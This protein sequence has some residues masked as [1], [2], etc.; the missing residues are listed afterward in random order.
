[1]TESDRTVEPG[2]LSALVDRDDADELWKNLSLDWNTGKVASG[3]R[4][5]TMLIEAGLA[6]MSSS[7]VGLNRKG[8]LFASRLLLPI[9]SLLKDRGSDLRA[10]NYLLKKLLSTGKNS[11]IYMAEHAILRSRVVVKILRPGA[12][13]DI[14]SSLRHLGMADI[15][16]AVVKP[17]DFAELEVADIFGNSAPVYCLVFPMV[18]GIHFSD[19]IAQKSS[20]LNSFVVISFIRQVG[21]AL[22]SLEQANAYHG[23]LHERNILVDWSPTGVLTFRIVDV[24]Y[25]SMGSATLEVCRN[26][27]LVRFRQHILKLLAEQ[28]HYLPR[29]SMRKY[30]GT[31][32]YTAIA[33]ILSPD[34]KS[35]KRVLSI[36]E[37]MGPA[38]DYATER[39]RF[40]DERFGTP[41]SFR[42]Q[43]FEE[44]V[45]PA[46]AIKLFVP[47]QELKERIEVFGNVY[48]SGNRGSGK[49][50]YLAS[51]AYFPTVTDS[52]RSFMTSFGIYFPCRQG[53]FA[54]LSAS[55]EMSE[56]EL[57]TRT[58]H[59]LIVKV[60]RR[61]IESLAGGLNKGNVRVVSDLYP[62]VDFLNRFVAGQGIVSVDGDII[63]ELESLV[64]SITRL[65]L[66]LVSTFRRDQSS[67]S[68]YA[69]PR[70][71]I[72][73]FSIVKQ[74]FSE[75]SATQFHILFDDAGAPYMPANVQRAVCDLMLASN[76]VFC[77]KLTAEKFTFVF[78]SS[79]DKV[80]ENGNDYVEQD[81]SAILF[82]GSHTAGLSRHRL[83]EYFR[84]IVEQRLVHF[85]YQT[86]DIVDYLGDG[87]DGA[88]KLIGLLA[89]GRKDAYYCGWT[90]VWNV[91]DRTPR[92]L[93]EIVSEI[94]AVGGIEPDTIPRKV[95]M[96]DQ[97][98][99]IRTISDKRLHSLNQIAGS[100]E[101]AGRTISLGRQ[102]FEVTATIGATFRHY[103]R[104]E[105]GRERKRQHLAL[106]RNDLSDLH[107]TAEFMLER[108][109]SFGILDDAKLQY[110][111]DDQVKKPVYVLNRI[112]CPAFGISYV[113][114]EHL[115]LS[116]GKI[117]ML[118]LN[119][120]LF[121]REGTA[122]LR[123]LPENQRDLFSDLFE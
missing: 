22:R 112:Y 101:V 7:G 106:E 76:S 48:V 97:D 70:D 37:D 104:A 78:Q 118:L 26:D 74:C 116:R 12:S 60:I 73:F 41:G 55:E 47:F 100:L 8:M 71:L 111:R 115:R 16:P 50:T 24:S 56:E 85:G 52:S 58:T 109:I 67:V 25:D 93:L 69:T 84:K 77:V 33:K 64:S 94:F 110:A 35:F 59:V 19:F 46:V 3:S 119:P 121:N 42:L 63:P 120:Q 21:A 82:I 43:R 31:R 32:F 68:V 34:T 9:H 17:I 38:N 113:R 123:A 29:M 65:E 79:S 96:R 49:S 103:L 86:T 72:D 62:I 90:T 105:I 15:H 13:E 18:E 57:S 54:S 81:I 98:R 14:V 11:A 117:E 36:I 80:L 1:M 23:D 88:Q 28:S 30:L 5:T 89:A 83:E 75:V 108:L 40:I 45:D 44:I 66:Q 61:T 4:M 122:R 2:K 102:I 95:T 53:E 20:F 107:P 87:Q 51:L 92:H 10:G 114:D 27:D 99:A 91:A 39:T 6:E